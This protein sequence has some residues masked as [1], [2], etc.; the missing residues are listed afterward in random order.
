MFEA[1][2]WHRND[3]LGC[4]S[5]SSIWDGLLV[6]SSCL[7][8]VTSPPRLT[9]R[10][11]AEDMHLI[12]DS[13]RPLWYQY[14]FVQERWRWQ[15][16][17]RQNRAGLTHHRGAECVQLSWQTALEPTVCSQADYLQLSE[18]DK[19]QPE[20]KSCSW[21]DTVQTWQRI[22]LQLN[23]CS[24]ATILSMAYSSSSSSYIKVTVEW[25]QPGSCDNIQS[26]S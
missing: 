23:D 16:C 19:L 22:A 6:N 1:V 5:S 14:K 24:K 3:V 15:E 4:T 12:H 9:T 13:N 17:C 25:D 2:A 10:G 21:A 20:P 26:R 8:A 7:Q 18:D 11:L